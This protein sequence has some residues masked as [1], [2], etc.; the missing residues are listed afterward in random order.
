VTDLFP[1]A[2]SQ[3][4]VEQPASLERARRERA[5]GAFSARVQSVLT[6]LQRRGLHGGTWQELGDVL[7]LHHGQISGALSVLHKAGA[8]F[9]TR[10]QRG[11]CHVYV[12]AALRDQFQETQRI[13]EPVRTK[14][15]IR[16]EALE[17]V[18]LAAELVLRFDGTDRLS[19]EQLREAVWEVR[20]L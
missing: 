6:E 17:A 16:R 8:V 7:G 19:L 4:H 1:Y 3:G 9:M 11:R 18:L 13:D 15:A 20:S 12:H 14:S 5:S 10:S 2:G